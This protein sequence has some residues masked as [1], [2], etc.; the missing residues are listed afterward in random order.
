MS[1]TLS[2]KIDPI[3]SK[4]KTEDV[5][6]SRRPLSTIGI[7]PQ[8]F[9]PRGEHEARGAEEEYINPYCPAPPDTEA[10][11]LALGNLERLGSKDPLAAA[12]AS[13]VA[14]SDCPS[15]PPSVLSL[16][17]HMRDGRERK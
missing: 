6:P 3:N 13:V 11:T 17:L 2:T 9:G 5:G 14:R 8:D 1:V 16:I 15:L 4:S 12:L 7:I 10:L